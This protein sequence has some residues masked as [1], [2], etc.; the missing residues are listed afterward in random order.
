M[1]ECSNCE[2]TYQPWRWVHHFIDGDHEYDRDAPSGE[3]ERYVGDDDRWRDSAAA[4]DVTSRAV[5]ACP[6]CGAHGTADDVYHLA[7]VAADRL[8]EEVIDR[9]YDGA[10]EVAESLRA[11][12][13]AAVEQPVRTVVEHR[14]RSTSDGFGTGLLVGA[15]LF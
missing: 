7:R 2:T 6:M 11:R 1:I 13:R 15:L 14:T 4:G 9:F 10:E 5:F 12:R 3:R 8:G